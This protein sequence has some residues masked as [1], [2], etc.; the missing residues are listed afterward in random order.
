MSVGSSVL[1]KW[2]D[3]R[4]ASVRELRVG[5]R[6]MV[7]ATGVELRSLPPQVIASAILL[8]R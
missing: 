7:W 6:V 4:T 5:R 2:R 3:G 8:T 1:L